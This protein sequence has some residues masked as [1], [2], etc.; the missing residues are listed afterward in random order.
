[1]SASHPRPPQRPDP[2]A[3]RFGFDERGLGADAVLRQLDAIARAE[4]ATWA[5]GRCSGT[6]YC[7]DRAI[8]DLIAEAFG[9]FSYVNVLQRDMCPSQTR[10]ESEIIAMTLDMLHGDA[11]RA[12]G[13]EPCGVIG[14]GGSESILSAIYAHREW[15]R[16][17]KGVAEPEMILP[18]TAHVAFDKGAHYFGVKVVR[19]PV[20]PATTRVDVD[21]VR[22]HV[23]RNTVL[24]VGSAGNYPY[25]TI[26]PIEALS[27]LALEHGT[28]LHVDGCLG[29]F[30]LPWGEALG[31]EIPPFDFRL[32]GVTT[33]SADTHKY[34]YGPKGTSLLLFHDKSLRRHQ[35]FARPDWKGGMYAS[36]GMGGSRSGGLIAATWAVMVAL[37]REGYLAKARKVFETSFAMQAAVRKHPELRLMGE[38]TFCFSFT[39][40]EFD[41]YHVNDAMKKRGW[42]FNG[43]Q[44]P[45]AIHMCVTGPQT[46][47][48]VVERF[49][50]DLAEAVAYARRPDQPVPRSGALYGGQGTRASAESIDMVSL[51]ERLKDWL[52]STLEQ[53]R[54]G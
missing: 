29:G 48:G 34:G 8:Y 24:L 53:P 47:P 12:R 30:I 13:K 28:G 43:Q 38:P 3:P 20:D 23:S 36:P 16:A 17:E 15:G 9:R 10:F 45:S 2:A 50:A 51:R 18:D 5:E 40:D 46:Q 32:P 27:E 1:M 11:A 35:Y 54:P 25:G 52:D 4:D 19:A 31:Y 42:R 49:A 39:S 22:D 14:S 44:F 26:D 33:I 7:G 41:I 37:G 6:I 21:F